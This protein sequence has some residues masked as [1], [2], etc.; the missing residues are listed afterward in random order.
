MKPTTGFERA[1]SAGT[2][3]RLRLIN[4]LALKRGRVRRVVDRHAADL[5]SWTKSLLVNAVTP[6]RRQAM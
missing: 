2:H 4:S 5:A 3:E 1:A 6:L